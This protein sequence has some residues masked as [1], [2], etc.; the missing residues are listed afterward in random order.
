MR[1]RKGESCWEWTG[2]LTDGY[3]RMRVEGRLV[4]AHRYS[5][6]AANGAIPNGLQVLHRC[7]NRRCVRPDHLFIGTIAD[8]MMDAAVKRRAACGIDS[9]RI[10][11][12][13]DIAPADLRKVSGRKATR[14]PKRRRISRRPDSL[15]ATKRCT[16]CGRTKPGSEFC[17]QL[18]RSR[19]PR[20]KSRCYDCESRIVREKSH[21]RTLARQTTH[22]DRF[23]KK[24]DKLSPP[25]G[26]WI[27]TGSKSKFGYGVFRTPGGCVGAH[28]VAWI[29]ANGAIQN[30]LRVCHK[31]DNPPCVNPAHLFLGTARDNAVDMALKKRNR[32]APAGAS[33]Y[34]AKLTESDVIE[35]RRRRTD[36]VGVLASDFNVSKA[37]IRLILKGMSWSH[38]SLD[39]MQDMQESQGLRPRQPS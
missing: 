37:C 13:R 32:A 3:G 9:R 29:L 39:G 34:F 33:N 22:E 5:W 24:V 38:L 10:V 21:C 36:R 2:P 14:P 4:G 7:D 12:T 19:P 31:C 18:D 11:R 16:S 26:C 35:I 28:R 20:L 15:P 30:G 8:N 1:V 23:W 17:V 6:I 25:G 27:W